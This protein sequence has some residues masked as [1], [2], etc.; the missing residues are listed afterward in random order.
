MALA[1]SAG[2]GGGD[3]RLRGLV[4]ELSGSDPRLRTDALA[5]LRTTD[6]PADVLQRIDP[7]RPLAE[8]PDAAAGL[9]AWVHATAGSPPP[10]L[11]ERLFRA[12]NGAGSSAAADAVAGAIHQGWWL[13]GLALLA[14]IAAAARGSPRV[15]VAVC[16]AAAAVVLALAAASVLKPLIHRARPDQLP[17]ATR[18][19]ES[20]TASSMPSRHAAAVAGAAVPLAALHPAA[21]VA[22]AGAALLTGWARV[23]GGYHYPGDVLAGWLLGLAA[24]WGVGFGMRRRG[25]I[26]PRPPVPSS[27]AAPGPI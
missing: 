23:Y 22:G 16:H 18:L 1:G 19:A 15:R 6:A 20:S 27:P 26:A 2:R 21:A 5:A 4:A 14:G 3:V 12:L 9:H 10:G 13:G 7:A 17:G 11:D 8:Q 24:A 25:W